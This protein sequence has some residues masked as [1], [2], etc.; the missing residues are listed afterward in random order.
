M[1]ATGGSIVTD[2]ETFSLLK[3]RTTTLW[4]K[5]RARDHWDR[6]VA[7]GD[8]R[9][10]RGRTNAMSELKSLL[11]E[12]KPLYAQATH[13]VDTSNVALDETVRAR[14]EGSEDGEPG[15][16]SPGE[17]KRDRYVRG[18][19]SAWSTEGGTSVIELQS[20]LE[21]KWVAGKGKTVT[22]VNPATEEPSAPR[23]LRRLDYGGLRFAR[24][25]GGAA[26]RAMSF[27]ARGEMIRAM[28]R[29]IHAH[30]DELIGLAVANRLGATPAP[31]RS[32]TST[33]PP[34]PSARP[35]PTS[36]RSS[37]ATCASSSTAT[38]PS[39]VAPRP[40]SSASMSCVPRHGVAVHAERLQLPRLGPGF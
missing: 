9:P 14:A 5:A 25:R 32:S 11:R 2:K 30:R 38:R 15:Q 23:R 36:R 22:L 24:E 7:Q 28:S 19:A 8:A 4:L 31:T 34:G 39:S 26:L 37:E 21:G 16:E 27:A 13:I 1:L 33:A 17:R 35:T 18:F 29:A 12:R 40:P 3:K 6:V 20:H 10:M